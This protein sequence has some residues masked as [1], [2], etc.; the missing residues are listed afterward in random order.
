[1]SDD[2]PSTPQD[3][4]C[5]FWLVILFVVWVTLPITGTFIIAKRGWNDTPFWIKWPYA[6]IMVGIACGLLMMGLE[7]V[8]I[9]Q[10]TP[11][12]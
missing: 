11:T 1:M 10:P 4:A 9:I 8:G 3:W 12:P 5:L 2:F 7:A 6:F